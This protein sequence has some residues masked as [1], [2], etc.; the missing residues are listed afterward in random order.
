VLSMRLLITILFVIMTCHGYLSGQVRVTKGSTQ[1]QSRLVTKEG[2]SAQIEQR[3]FQASI[4]IPGSTK[5]HQIDVVMLYDPGSGLFWWHY[6][7]VEPGQTGEADRFVA[8]STFNILG[9]RLVCFTFRAGS[10]WVGES[11]A[12]YSSLPEGQSKVMDTIRNRSGEISSG[13]LSVFHKVDLGRT[14]PFT[15]YEL[16][17]N[18]NPL[19]QPKLRAVSRLNGEWRLILDGPNGD[20]AIVQLND[21]Y[22]ETGSKVVSREQAR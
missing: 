3:S 22:E 16:N 7:L 6:L 8:N 14:L 5:P 21:K 18:S 9:P 15:F 10:L 20:S 4:A 11:T 1:K 2:L 17:G 19:I 13:T 12:H